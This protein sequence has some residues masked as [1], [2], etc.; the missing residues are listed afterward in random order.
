MNYKILFTAFPVASSSSG[1]PKID[2]NSALEL[3]APKQ[4]L[5]ELLDVLEGHVENL[6]KEAIKLEEDRDSLLSSLDS[7]RNSDLLSELAES[8]KRFYCEMKVCFDRK[9]YF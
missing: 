8:K 7:V 4:V 3:K 5:I 1:L 2:E 9:I 6:R